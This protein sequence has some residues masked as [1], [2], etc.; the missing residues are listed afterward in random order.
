MSD[1]GELIPEFDTAL[2]VQTI[3]RSELALTWGER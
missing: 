3:G 1:F 2:E